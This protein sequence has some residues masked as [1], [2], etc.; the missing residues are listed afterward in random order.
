[1]SAV[2]WQMGQTAL[3]EEHFATATFID[4]KWRSMEFVHLQTRWPPKLY[5]AMQRFLDI[6]PS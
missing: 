3:A 6:A 1:M 2:K 5:A 4:P